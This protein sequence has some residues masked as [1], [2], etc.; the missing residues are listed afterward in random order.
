MASIGTLITVFLVIPTTVETLTR[1]KSLGKL[2]MG[3][4][5]VRDDAGRSPSS[6]RSSAR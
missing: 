1:G 2:A 6:T 3:L 5:T 4:R